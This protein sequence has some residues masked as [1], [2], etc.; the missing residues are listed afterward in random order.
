MVEKVDTARVRLWDE[1]IGAVTWLADR[2]YGL[3]E[4]EPSFL[5]KSL[6]L[7]PI[8]MGFSGVR[9]GDGLF[10]FPGL[11]RETFLGLPFGKF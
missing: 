8:H 7:S 6:D 1:D 3:F 11:N 10:F 5:R 2:G 4:Y 9:Q